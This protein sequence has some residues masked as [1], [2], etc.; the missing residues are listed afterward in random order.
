MPA[1]RASTDL[2]FGEDVLFEREE[3]AIDHA[4]QRALGGVPGRQPLGESSIDCFETVERGI[5]LRDLNLGHCEATPF[6]TLLEPTREEGLAAAV[7]A[8]DGLEDASPGLHLGELLVERR[9]EALQVDGEGVEARARNRS[10]PERVDDLLASLGA[11]HDGRQ[12]RTVRPLC[13]LGSLPRVRQPPPSAAR[14]RW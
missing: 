11:D 13:V 8:S 6:R 14:G 4:P 3:P 5:C 10:A 7:L 12:G 9:L 1:G 2:P